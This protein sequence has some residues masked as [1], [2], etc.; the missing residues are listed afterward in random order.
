MNYTNKDQHSFFFKAS[1]LYQYVL[2]LKTW[3]YSNKR[4]C[5][6]NCFRLL[7]RRLGRFNSWRQ[8][9]FSWHCLINLCCNQLRMIWSYCTPVLNLLSQWTETTKSKSTVFSVFQEYFFCVSEIKDILLIV[10]MSNN[11]HTVHMY[12]HLCFPVTSIERMY[13]NQV[14]IFTK[15]IYDSYLLL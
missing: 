11:L 2:H 3:I 6:Q 5:L 4:N 9:F 1:I 14:F 8:F 7:I 10:S 13:V 15:D 12:V